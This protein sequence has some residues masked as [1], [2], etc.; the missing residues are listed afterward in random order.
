MENTE[1]LQELFETRQD[2][3]RGISKVRNELSKL[4]KEY[5]I[6]N[7]LVGKC[8]RYAYNGNVIFL[9]VTNIIKY[10]ENRDPRI[11]YIG[12]QYHD[13]EEAP[14]IYDLDEYGYEIPRV[15]V[16]LENTKDKPELWEYLSSNWGGDSM[17]YFIYG[18]E[19]SNEEFTEKMSLWFNAIINK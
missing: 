14:I 12:L 15:A 6:D 16:N 13:E 19:I 5:L 8:I 2:Y 9:K 1:K 10:E 3:Y 7:D 11:Q 18:K 4:Y 17:H